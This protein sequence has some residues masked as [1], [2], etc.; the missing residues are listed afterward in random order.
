MDGMTLGE[1]V[2]MLQAAEVLLGKEASVT[3]FPEANGISNNR[4]KGIGNICV[5]VNGSTGNVSLHYYGR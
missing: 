3:C 4:V 5:G 1:L 2:R